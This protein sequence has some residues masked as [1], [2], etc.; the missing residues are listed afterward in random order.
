[1]KKRT[2]F[3]FLP[4][5]AIGLY[6]TLAPSCSK[7]DDN[8]SDI[9]VK[10]IDGN[11]YHTVTIGTQVWMVENLKTTKYRNGDPIPNYTDDNEWRTLLIGAFCNYDNNSDNCA[12]YGNLYNWYAVEDS[13]NIAPIG[14]HVP[15]DEEWTTL[16]NYVA[17]NLGISGSV[18]KALASTIIWTS[19]N[20]SGAIGN[21]LTKNNSTGFTAL[22]GGIRSNIGVFNLIRRYGFWW[23]STEDNSTNAFCQSMYYGGSNLGDYSS[24]S[25]ENGFSVRCLKDN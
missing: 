4:I 1:M 8:N 21:D 10:D 19:I 18:A 9:T 14:W 3:W 13:R 23:S 12:T 24:G 16:E 15:T 22:P 7:D 11:I 6:L 2:K 25:K 5:V 20:T 17:A